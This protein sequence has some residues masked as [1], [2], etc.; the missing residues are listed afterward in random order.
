[1]IKPFK[2]DT[3]SSVN[4]AEATGYHLS[5]SLEWLHGCQFNCKGCHVNKG[6]AAYTSEQLYELGNWLISMWD[7]GGYLPTIVFLAPTDFLAADNIIDVLTNVETYSILRQFKRLSLQTTF[8]NIDR[9]EEIVKI[10][11]QSYSHME[12]ELNFII[13]PE[14][15]NN[16]KYL[17]TIR[18]NREKFIKSLEWEKHIASFAI[19][20]VYEYDRIKKNDVKNILADYQQLHAKIMEKFGST[21]DFNFSMTRNAWW[22]NQDIQEAVQSV[23]RIFDEGV[24]HEFNQTIRFSFG[25]LEDSSI[26]KHY[27][28]HQGDLYISPM[29]YERIASFNEVLKVPVRDVITTESHEQMLLIEQYQNADKKTK[30]GTC[31]YQA[32]CIERNVLAFMDM[33]EIKDCIIAS[34]ALDS[35]NVITKDG[36]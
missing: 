13:E 14:K 27:N 22:S 30:C 33:H 21:I 20:N 26:E 18:D 5:L 11:K 28:W 35:I 32:S 2:Q 4:I 34:K 10:L 3:Q 25:K 29:I 24:N 8:L 36:S 9:A 6:D 1:M 23:S 7:I 17:N 19:M 31:R 12:L 15:V 16:E